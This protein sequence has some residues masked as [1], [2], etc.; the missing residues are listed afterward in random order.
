M[1]AGH[2]AVEFFFMAWR[3]DFIARC[4]PKKPAAAL[5]NHAVRSSIGIAIESAAFGVGGIFC[6]A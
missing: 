2:I 4:M 5:T 1:E 3:V 6:N